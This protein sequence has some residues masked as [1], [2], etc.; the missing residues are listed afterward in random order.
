M[1]F[2]VK[3]RHDRRGRLRRWVTECMS[4]HS[5][6]FAVCGKGVDSDRLEDRTQLLGLAR[7]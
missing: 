1:R 7:A 5:F 3:T 6:E 4:E 2:G